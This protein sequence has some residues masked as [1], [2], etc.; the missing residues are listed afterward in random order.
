MEAS[1][2]IAFDF[3]EQSGQGWIEVKIKKPDTVYVKIQGTIWY[4]NS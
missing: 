1:G 3:P 2:N 4:F